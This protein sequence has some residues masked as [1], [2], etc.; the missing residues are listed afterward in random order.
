[1]FRTTWYP[2]V[3]TTKESLKLPV[4]ILPVHKISLERKKC[5]GCHSNQRKLVLLGRD[6]LTNLELVGG[7]LYAGW[8]KDL[9]V[10]P[11]FKCFYDS[12]RLCVFRSWPDLLI[13]ASK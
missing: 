5:R 8:F 2:P 3:F 12:F 1:M 11:D 9:G 4:E 7:L 6:L 10:L 13:C